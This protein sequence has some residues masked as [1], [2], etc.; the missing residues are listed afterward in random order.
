MSH[1]LEITGNLGEP[2]TFTFTMIDVKSKRSG[3]V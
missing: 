2:F 3:N 1:K